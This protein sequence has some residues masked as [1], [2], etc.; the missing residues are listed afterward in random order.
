VF[1][2]FVASGRVSV[3]AA[4]QSV[5]LDEGEGT[6]IAAPGAPP[7]PPVPWGEAR[8]RAALASVQ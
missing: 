7:S 8:I 6:N 2:V 1:G 3:Q 5:L 4:N